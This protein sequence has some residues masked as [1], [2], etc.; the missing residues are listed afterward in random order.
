MYI[1]ELAKLSGTSA[2]AIRHYENLG[3][4]GQVE[5]QG[6]YRIYDLQDVQVVQW[7]KQAQSLGFR[8]NELVAAFQKDADGQL[9]WQEMNRQI[10]FKRSAICQEI[11]HL[12]SLEA[13]LTAMHIEIDECISGAPLAAE[14]TPDQAKFYAFCAEAQST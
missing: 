6:V 8:L 12:Q 14:P 3:L 7:I 10:E 9:N 2:K 1:G 5:R 4:L 13:R 11:A